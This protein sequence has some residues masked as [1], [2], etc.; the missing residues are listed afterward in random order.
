MQYKLY[1]KIHKSMNQFF[2]KDNSIQ[3][4]QRIIYLYYT[5]PI[6]SLSIGVRSSGTISGFTDNNSTV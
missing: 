2:L 4:M 3:S 5:N 1:F 6:L